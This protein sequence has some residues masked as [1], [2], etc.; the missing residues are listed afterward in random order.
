MPVFQP[1]TRTSDPTSAITNIY[2]LC[3]TIF[4]GSF[5]RATTQNFLAALRSSETSIQRQSICETCRTRQTYLRQSTLSS[6]RLL[7]QPIRRIDQLHIYAH[8]V[9]TLLH[10]AFQDVSY[11]KLLADLGQVFRHE[12]YGKKYADPRVTPA[13]RIAPVTRSSSGNLRNRFCDKRAPC[14]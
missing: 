7:R 10:A 5:V 9:G 8:G 3:R 14:E 11:A 6:L 4:L 2:F 1:Q 13:F 12:K